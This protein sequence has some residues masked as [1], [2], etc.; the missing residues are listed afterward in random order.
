MAK[1]DVVAD[2]APAAQ[3]GIAAD[4]FVAQAPRNEAAL[5]HPMARPPFEKATP[6]STLHAQRRAGEM[7]YLE[8]NDSGFSRTRGFVMMLGV[9]F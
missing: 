6:K 5:P 7:A 2:A 4:R 1:T 8:H 3:T 9:G